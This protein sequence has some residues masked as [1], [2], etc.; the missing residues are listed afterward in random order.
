MD[1]P[2]GIAANYA[3]LSR[4]R[5][6]STCSAMGIGCHGNVHDHVKKGIAKV[7]ALLHGCRVTVPLSSQ[8]TAR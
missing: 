8:F 6:T 2:Q 3:Y 4:L 7:M 1:A 5:I